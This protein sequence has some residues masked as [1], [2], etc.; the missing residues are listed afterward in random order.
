MIQNRIVCFRIDEHIDHRIA[1]VLGSRYFTRSELPLNICCRMKRAKRQIPSLR[2]ERDAE[3]CRKPSNY[4][5]VHRNRIQQPNTYHPGLGHARTPAE[6][7]GSRQ[8]VQRDNRT[9]A[10]ALQLPIC[11]KVRALSDCLVS[12]APE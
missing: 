10:L 8:L 9:L 11:F 7:S 6:Q 5:H 2:N 4:R 1:C 12:S 3:G